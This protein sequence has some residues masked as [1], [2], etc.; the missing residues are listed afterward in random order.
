MRVWLLKC[1]QSIRRFWEIPGSARYRSGSVSDSGGSSSSSSSVVLTN[2]YACDAA[3]RLTNQFVGT[4]ARR[5]F[6]TTR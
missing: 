6:G 2:R 1:N 5:P 3:G 4:Q